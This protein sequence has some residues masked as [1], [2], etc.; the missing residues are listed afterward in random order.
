MKEKAKTMLAAGLYDSGT[1]FAA[2]HDAGAI[3]YAVVVVCNT[4][5]IRIRNSRQLIDVVIHIVVIVGPVDRHI[6]P[7][8]HVIVRIVCINK[9]FRGIDLVVDFSEPVAQIVIVALICSE[10]S[11]APRYSLPSL[12]S[13]QN[14]ER[15][16]ETQCRYDQ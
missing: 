16:H 3:A 8:A 1:L 5:R 7:V 11:I 12:Y 4:R 2:R 6:Q 9:R 15:L 14:I 10:R 13:H